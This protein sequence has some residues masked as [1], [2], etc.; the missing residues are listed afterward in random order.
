MERLIKSGGGGAHAEALEEAVPESIKNIVLV[1]ANAGYLVPSATTAGEDSRT[2]M[3]RE[4]W[5]ASKTRME[6]LLP[7]LLRDVF[8]DDGAVRV[9]RRDLATD[10]KQGGGEA[11]EISQAKTVEGTA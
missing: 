2:E 6:R 8:G 4:M 7:G 5:E 10:E 9:T 11:G 3:Q 1:M